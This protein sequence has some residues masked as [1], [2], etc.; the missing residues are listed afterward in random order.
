MNAKI[1]AAAAL[2]VGM[3]TAA[4]TTTTEGDAKSPA[5]AGAAVQAGTKVCISDLAGV[6]YALE[7]ALREQKLE[8]ARSCT[9]AKIRMQ[10]QGAPRAWILRYQHVGDRDWKECRSAESER[11]AFAEQCIGQMLTD[12]GG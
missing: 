12:L 4:C 11:H 8:P 7:D 9:S 10:E 5:D 2:V 1:L 3:A 6:R